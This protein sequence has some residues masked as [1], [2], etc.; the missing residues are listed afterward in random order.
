MPASFSARLRRFDRLPT[1]RATLLLII[2]ALLA[3]LALAF[4]L[5]SGRYVST[6]N[7]YVGAQKVL[8]T[9]E[10]S[11]K[12]VSIAVQEGQLLKRGD[13]LFAIDPVPYRLAAQEAQAKLARVRTDFENLKSNYVS[14]GRRIE[15]SRQALDAAQSDYD[16]KLALLNNRISTPSD[17][18][19]SRAALVA[20]KAQLELLQQEEAGG[21]IQLLGDPELPLERF[22]QY[23][24]ALTMLDR[25]RRDLENTTLRAPIA[26]IA[27]QV[28]SIQMGRYLVAGAAVFSIID[29]ANVWIDAN[30]KE[31]DLTHVRPG[32][33]VAIT[34]DAF[35]ARHWTGVVAAISPGTGAQ[36]SILPPQNAAGNW[37]K[38]VQR[39]PV[40]I[41]FAAGQDLRR[42]R[43]GMS[44]TVE[45]DTGRVGR[46]ASFFSSSAVAE[47]PEE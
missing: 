46:F 14:I 20:T 15:L 6:D 8:I 17:V 12:V 25:A 18:D 27:T 3:C 28:T 2:P 40:R 30:P 41:E 45:I 21:R 16:R 44:A 1:L 38:I 39:V 23:V 47:A 13:E 37:I 31:T 7:A 26:G 11:G 35:P 32:Q 19:R 5:F 24:E 42:L 36:F 10:V 34:V 4:Y 9:P 33:P 22:P 43:S 29:S